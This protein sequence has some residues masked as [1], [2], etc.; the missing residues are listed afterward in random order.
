MLHQTCEIASGIVGHK[1]PY[2][3]TAAMNTSV[4]ELG[5]LPYRQVGSLR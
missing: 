5:A 1:T 3:E 2:L 4:I